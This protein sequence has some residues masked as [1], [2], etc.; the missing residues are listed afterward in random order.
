M[1]YSVP[2]YTQDLLATASNNGTRSHQ[3]NNGTQLRSNG[4]NAQSKDEQKQ[5]ESIEGMLN[6]FSKALGKLESHIQRYMLCVSRPLD[7][8]DV[9]Q[10]TFTY[11]S[12]RLCLR[13]SYRQT[14]SYNHVFDDN[15]DQAMC[16]SGASYSVFRH[17]KQ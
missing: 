10:V 3:Q 17:R 7:D 11:T 5:G 1:Y 6:N 4:L 2:S 13:E 12:C 15:A 9:Q 14:I 8:C 16:S